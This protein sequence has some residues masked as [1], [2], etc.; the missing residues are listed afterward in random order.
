MYMDAST[1]NQI[2]HDY[3]EITLDSALLIARLIKKLRL[4]NV[5]P[6][7]NSHSVEIKVD[8]K[9]VYKGETG[10]Q[11][12]VNKLTS[13]QLQMLSSIIGSA[14]AKELFVSIDGEP[15][16]HSL[17]GTVEIDKLSSRPQTNAVIPSQILQLQAPS[18]DQEVRNLQVVV[19]ARRILNALQTNDYKSEKYHL[20]REGNNI[21][22]SPNNVD[23]ALVRIQNGIITGL[24]SRENVFQLSELE[25]TVDRENSVKSQPSAV[26]S[27]NNSQE[28]DIE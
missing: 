21:I 28:I 25:K 8:N 12:Q 1:A 27:S 11:P 6:K 13:D 24:A 5:I 18:S 26:N 23:S 10:K 19:A 2:A 17:N 16:Y 15:V 14:S 7:K 9:L 4:N 20:H 22:V 3:Q